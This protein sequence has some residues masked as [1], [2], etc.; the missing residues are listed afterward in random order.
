M[1]VRKN[2]EVCAGVRGTSHCDLNLSGGVFPLQNL[3]VG[4]PLMKSF[5]YGVCVNIESKLLLLSGFVLLESLRME[6][7]G[8]MERRVRH[9]VAEE[10]R[11]RLEWAYGVRIH[12]DSLTFSCRIVQRFFDDVEKGVEDRECLLKRKAA[13]LLEAACSL[14]RSQIDAGEYDEDEQRY[15]ADEYK[16]LRCQVEAHEMRKEKD[17]AG[18]FWLL[19]V[20]QEL[21]DSTRRLDQFVHRWR[22]LLLQQQEHSSKDNIQVLQSA[23]EDIQYGWA[24]NSNDSNFLSILIGKLEGLV[25]L[26]ADRVSPELGRVVMVGP[27]LIAEVAS[28]LTGFRPW[29]PYVKGL[30]KRLHRRQ[31]GKYIAILTVFH[32]LSRAASKPGPLIATRPIGCF[33]FLCGDRHGGP[34][35]AEALADELFDGLDS[36]IQFD[37]LEYKDPCS[38]SRLLG[39]PESQCEPCAL[40]QLTEA[41]KSSP[42]SVVL[43]SNIDV[44]HPSV[45]DILI[46]IVSRGRLTDGQGS[47]VDFTK[48]LIIM[49]SKLGID[50]QLTVTCECFPMGG[51]F[52]CKEILD[53]H[54]SERRDRCDVFRRLELV[55]L[56]FDY[57]K[58]AARLRLREIASSMTRRGLIIYPSEAALHLILGWGSWWTGGETT[59]KAWMEE[60]LVPELRDMCAKG[61]IDDNHI[62]YIDILVGEAKLSYKL[63]KCEDFVEDRGLRQLKESSAELRGLCKEEKQ[64]VKRIFLSQR[65][66]YKLKSSVGTCARIDSERALEAIQEVFSIIDS[67]VKENNVNLVEKVMQVNEEAELTQGE[68]PNNKKAEKGLE[69]IKARLHAD[70]G[71]QAVGAISAAALRII[72]MPSND[73]VVSF[74]FFGLTLCGK[75]ELVND[76][77]EKFVTADGA[78]LLIQIN[79]SEYSESGSVSRLMDAFQ[80]EDCGMQLPGAV[81]MRPCSIIF[82]DQVE[83]AHASVFSA[84]LSVLDHN[85]FRDHRGR[86]VDFGDTIVIITSDLGNKEIIACLVDHTYENRKRQSAMKQGG[87]FRWE[88]LTRVDELVFSNPFAAK[89]DELRKKPA[90]DLEVSEPEKAALKFKTEVRELLRGLI[91]YGSCS[92]CITALSMQCREV[93]LFRN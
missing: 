32:A 36:L 8:A 28:S 73:P 35:L 68:E 58:A 62:I 65:M 16:L 75:E 12:E 18:R 79:L 60:N 41:V 15:D 43:F 17:P 34:E 6:D 83:K 86:T 61:E 59:V 10:D 71:D 45:I 89:E 80:S 70:L 53:R 90:K 88:L 23:R 3:P 37:L 14:L 9:K 64:R 74:L 54:P 7:S 57:C 91:G 69:Y 13:D 21:K 2:D 29:K 44:A 47:T 72:D 4:I 27:S 50:K 22:H 85:M 76:L 33:L 11:K 87:I 67:M 5:P 92:C 81:R 51:E 46:E 40:G 93:H 25:N 63:V 1:P 19:R 31:V 38:A 66:L 52:P 49:T 55:S 78:K 77:A 26:L 82:L 39:V 48:T 24:H 42:F 56:T 30:D 20:E 84:L